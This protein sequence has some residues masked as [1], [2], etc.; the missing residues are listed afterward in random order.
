MTPRAGWRRCARPRENTIASVTDYLVGTP[1]ARRLPR[2][3]S[4]RPRAVA[5]GFRE[6]LIPPFR[7]DAG[8][9][10]LS[11]KPISSA[12][13]RWSGSPRRIASAGIFGP[14]SVTW[15]IDREAAIFLGAG[16]ALLL[17]LAHPWVAAAI[18]EHSRT[19]SRSD[20]PVSPHLQDHLHDGVRHHRSG[21]RRRP[22]PAPAPRRDQRH[23][24]A[25]VPAPLPPARPI[26]P[27]TSRRCAGFMATLTD[28]ALLAYRAR[29]PAAFDRGSRALLRRSSACSRR[30]SASRKTPCRKSWAGFADYVDDMLGSD[31]LAV[32]GAARRIAAELFS[33]AGTGWRVPP[34]YR[35]LTA[36]LLPP[37]LRQDFGLPYGRGRASL[38]RAGAD[39][40]S[41]S[42]SPAA[43]RS[44]LCRALPRGSSPG[45]PGE[46]RPGALTRALNRFWIGQSSMAIGGK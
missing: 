27:M 37:R 7:D 34:W 43:G 23:P 15:R 11:P 14:D 36:S 38:G 10:P 42:L 25:R 17:Q 5:R 22:P 29:Q 31:I 39:R 33:G 2:R 20:R 28:T 9:T 12:S 40:A 41:L 1:L 19:L 45:L 6:R 16:R 13:W 30:F 8:S 35:A 46:T 18:A 24:D 21:A 3:G 44:A 26:G 4:L 32:S